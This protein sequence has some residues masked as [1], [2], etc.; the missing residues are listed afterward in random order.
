M[1]TTKR[2]FAKLSAQEPMKVELNADRLKARLPI[3]EKTLADASS[4]ITTAM[5][6]GNQFMEQLRKYNQAMKDAD[7]MFGYFN[8]SDIFLKD[9][10]KLRSDIA[11]A[12]KELGV[13][14]D[15]PFNLDRAEQTIKEAID[16]AAK[17]KNILSRFPQVKM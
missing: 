10:N 11:K 4:T 1:S 9:L 7:I 6:E 13:K 14:V 16:V 5:A 8:G 12:E 17:L 15:P 2:V 3:M